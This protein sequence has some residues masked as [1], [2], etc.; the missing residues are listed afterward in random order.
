MRSKITAFI[1]FIVIAA[2][3]LLSLAGCSDDQSSSQGSDRSYS[4]SITNN[5]S[6]KE[7]LSLFRSQDR[8]RTVICGP[9]SKFEAH[10]TLC[11]SVTNGIILYRCLIFSFYTNKSEGAV[12]LSRFCCLRSDD[13]FVVINLGQLIVLMC[14]EVLGEVFHLCRMLMELIFHIR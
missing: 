1:L 2:L 14:T 8:R 5:S 11:L 3:P 13:A 12:T 10:I 7:N 6:Q 9:L 4:E